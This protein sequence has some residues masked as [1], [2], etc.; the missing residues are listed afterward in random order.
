MTYYMSYYKYVAAAAPVA[1]GDG[2][3]DDLLG[4]LVRRMPW[5]AW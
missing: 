3:L 1:S 5:L 2:V 4:I